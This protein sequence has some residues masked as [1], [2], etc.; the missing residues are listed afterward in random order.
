MNWYILYCQTLK[1]EQLYQMFNRKKDIKAFIP[2]MEMYRRDRDHL[3]LEKMFPGYLFIK[4]HRN[5]EQFNDFLMNLKE[6]KDGVIK[7]L[8]KEDVSAL[9]NDEIQFFENL[10]DEKGIVKM[11]YGEKISNHSI[12]TSGPLVHYSKNIRRVDFYRN[13]AYLDI[14][15]LGREIICGFTVKRISKI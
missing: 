14:Q 8:R 5:Q 2:M 9:T 10:L 12:A 7:E 11:S 6:Q 4:T 1:T 13:L 3:I 15:F